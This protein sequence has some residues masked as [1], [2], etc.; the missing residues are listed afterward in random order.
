MLSELPNIENCIDSLIVY[1]KNNTSK[2]KTFIPHNPGY[3]V[4][5]LDYSPFMAR[6]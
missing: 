4:D 2:R 6:T 3:F 1:G 5:D